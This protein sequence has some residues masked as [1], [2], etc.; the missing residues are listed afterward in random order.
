KLSANGE[1]VPS[2]AK[3]IFP[4]W[5]QPTAASGNSSET[6]D[7][8]SGKTATSCTPDGAKETQTN[9]NATGFSVDKF[10]TG[11]LNSNTA[12]G[13]DDVHDCNDQPPSIT[14]TVP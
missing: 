12:G 2:P 4:S 1:I 14:L 6:I 8:V 10:V 7:K 5:Y 13:T 11:S 9:S 3:D